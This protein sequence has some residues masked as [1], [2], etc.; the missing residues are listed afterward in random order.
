M[1]SFLNQFFLFV[2]KGTLIAICHDFLK[3]R[4]RKFKNS[5]SKTVGGKKLLAK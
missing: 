5:C 4:L 2:E 1:L 3:T